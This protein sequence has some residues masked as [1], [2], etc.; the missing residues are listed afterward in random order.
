MNKALKTGLCLLGL[1]TASKDL[2]AQ[3]NVYH[4]NHLSVF[5]HQNG[6]MHLQFFVEDKKQSENNEL[7]PDQ[8]GNIRFFFK[9]ARPLQEKDTLRNYDAETGKANYA[10]NDTLVCIDEN[11][12]DTTFYVPSKKPTTASFGKYKGA[13]LS[14]HTAKPGTHD[15][16]EANKILADLP[17]QK[18]AYINW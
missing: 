4:Y 13:L 15:M 18:Y 16:V 2:S 11:K 9:N 7:S 12:G 5:K 10:L 8:K 6:E 14:I 1:F 3:N 17:K